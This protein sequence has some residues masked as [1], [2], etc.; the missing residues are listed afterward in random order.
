MTGLTIP[1]AQVGRAERKD[2]VR[3]R[4]MYWYE[5]LEEIGQEMAE[6]EACCKSEK[7]GMEMLFRCEQEIMCIQEALFQLKQQMSVIH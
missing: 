1:T 6:I 2:S 5:R 3:A 4:L 7:H